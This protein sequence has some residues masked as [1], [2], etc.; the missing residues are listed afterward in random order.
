MRAPM[1]RKQAAA[2]FECKVVGTA[3]LNA[4]TPQDSISIS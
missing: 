4:E 1:G 2:T 3:M